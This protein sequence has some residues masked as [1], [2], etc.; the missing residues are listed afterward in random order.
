MWHFCRQSIHLWANCDR[1]LS[2]LKLTSS[3]VVG[4][5]SSYYEEETVEKMKATCELHGHYLT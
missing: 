5:V 3:I 2:T 1:Q 4:K